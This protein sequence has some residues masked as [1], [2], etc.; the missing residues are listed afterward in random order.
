M[1]QQAIL[2]LPIIEF[3]PFRA[4]P[5]RLHAQCIETYGVNGLAPHADA[6]FHFGASLW[7]YR[8]AESPKQV[9]GLA[10][11]YLGAL[12]LQVAARRR[13]AAARAGTRSVD[14]IESAEEELENAG[15]HLDDIT[16]LVLDFVGDM[17]EQAATEP[18]RAGRRLAQ[19][20][21][22]MAEPGWSDELE[23]C[24][25]GFM[26]SRPRI[27]WQD[28]LVDVLDALEEAALPPATGNGHN[29]LDD[30]LVRRLH[31]ELQEYREIA[32]TA[33]SRLQ[34]VDSERRELERLLAQT[35]SD[36]SARSVALD[37]VREE[38]EHTLGEA[39]RRLETLEQMGSAAAGPEL[40]KLRAERDRLADELL[41]S[42][43]SATETETSHEELIEHLEQAAID[44][45]QAADAIG[46]LGKRL[47]AV[48][49]DAEATAERADAYRQRMNELEDQVDELRGELA[50]AEQRNQQA[51]AVIAALENAEG[52]NSEF[53]SFLTDAEA[54]LADTEARLEDTQLRVDALSGEL[55]DTRYEL[56]KAREKLAQQK[57]NLD[58]V[59]GQL[60]EAETLAGE[61]D[62]RINE[63][64]R[65]NERLRRDLSDAQTRMLDAKG[66]MDEARATEQNLQVELK[67]LNERISE[68]KGKAERNLRDKEQA[69]RAL[70]AAQS[71]L[72]TATASHQTLAEH[73]STLESTTA[74]IEK[75]Q[76]A[77][78]REIKTLRESL[79]AAD[80][81]AG[82]SEKALAQ[83]KKDLRAF[84]EAAAKAE[85]S[86]A[87]AATAR[88]KADADLKAMRDSAARTKA[89]LADAL[90]ERVL[91]QNQLAEVR[92]EV[93]A[94]RDLAKDR[95]DKLSEKL[96]LTSERLQRRDDERRMLLDNLTT[97]EDNRRAEKEELEAVMQRTSTEVTSARAKLQS[98]NADM[99][100]LQ[101]KLNET[102]TFL[103]ARQRELEKS[104]NRFRSLI[105]EVG[106]VAD[107][108]T[109]YEKAETDTQRGKL[110]SQIS[111]RIDSLFSAAGKPVHADRRTEKI[112]ILHVKKNDAE[113]EAESDKPFVA[114][115]GGD[116]SNAN[117]PSADAAE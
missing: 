19:N 55:E 54:R 114:T 110:A 32:T 76:R 102:E 89:E 8:E 42:L 60:A 31:G 39:R 41:N 15:A 4:S 97:A 65:E 109:Q 21:E 103:I 37:E 17:L 6:A 93:L 71:E 27:R 87:E 117:A 94:A 22:S 40:E 64:E 58:S 34:A 9:A 63:L 28:D 81:R 91:L 47:D 33:S 80:A 10:A 101:D 88:E 29:L 77:R 61:R 51:Q 36:F 82:E 100:R 49:R 104:E 75:T 43:S 26:Q 5:D 50:D 53:E 106:S 84:N 90:A 72:A 20:I 116:N 79:A 99:K 16:R 1:P 115:K 44:R 74:E 18:Q 62:D 13:L 24:A 112:L 85:K 83:A 107:L 38:L 59:S 73:A 66:D 105:D 2:D 68:E 46:S 30:Q 3:E 78:D 67:R 69:A 86:G 12:S 35:E 95:H 113:I 45:V 7:R 70:Q 96:A 11:G 52:R 57:A 56:E 108:R 48:Q 14:S 98:A 111:K 23:E 25:A 92:E